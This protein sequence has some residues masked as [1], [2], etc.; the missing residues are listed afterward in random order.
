[1]TLIKRISRNRTLLVFGAA[2][3]LLPSACS[4]ASSAGKPAG[5]APLPP[6]GA[7]TPT[8]VTTAPEQAQ[9][10][11]TLPPIPPAARE[12]LQAALGLQQGEPGA[13]EPPPDVVDEKQTISGTIVLPAANRA[14]VARG[15][16][17]FLAA[18]RA[19]GPP[20]PGSMLAV[21]KLT[22][23]EFPMRF[24]I[25]SRDA[26]IPGI[27]FEGQMAITVRVD[28]DG[29]AMT[30]RKGDVFGQADSVK[31]GSQKVVI[32]LDKVQAEDRTLGAP[33]PGGNEA[34]RAM[35]PAGHP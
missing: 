1:L 18:R 4:K 16:V 33:G 30:R 29:D 24:S 22:A 7:A 17:M 2:A 15:D 34:A 12:A 5:L 25:S 20:G 35:L 19:G 23:G 28:K 21:Q 26:M 9:A 10:P 3:W 32:S 6:S 8:A 31:V 13:A 27:P 11:N 14:K